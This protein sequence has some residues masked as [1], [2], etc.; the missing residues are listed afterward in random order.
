MKA[1]KVLGF[2]GK[3]SILLVALICN[4]FLNIVGI[5]VSAIAR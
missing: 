1:L 2:L 5:L 3:V 4:I